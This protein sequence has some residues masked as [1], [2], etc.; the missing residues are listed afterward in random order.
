MDYTLA[1]LVDGIEVHDNKF[2]FHSGEYHP[3]EFRDAKVYRNNDEFVLKAT[4][5]NISGIGETYEN[6]ISCSIYPEL[7]SAQLKYLK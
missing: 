6:I 5:V 1:I 3:I 4:I 2:E 7:S